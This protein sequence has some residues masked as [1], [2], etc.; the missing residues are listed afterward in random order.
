MCSRR[1]E[2][3]RKKIRF[4]LVS[5]PVHM[6]DC[7][8]TAWQHIPKMRPSHKKGTIA[9]MF[10]GTRDLKCNGQI[11]TETFPCFDFKSLRFMQNFN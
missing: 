8:D 2:E 1:W 10:F 9:R 3:S 5:E 6:I 7:T 4:Q 11:R